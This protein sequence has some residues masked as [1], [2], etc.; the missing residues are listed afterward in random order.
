MRMSHPWNK[1]PNYDAKRAIHFQ[2]YSNGQAAGRRR[3]TYLR[4]VTSSI[5]ACTGK[6]WIGVP[7]DR[8]SHIV[9]LGAG[10][11]SNI[12][13]VPGVCGRESSSSR[14]LWQCG[15][16]APT[17]SFWYQQLIVIRSIGCQPW[18]Y[19]AGIG[20]LSACFACEMSVDSKRAKINLL[21]SMNLTR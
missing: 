12:W 16:C 13:G 6:C 8:F 18:K 2:P 7:N 14:G 5:I 4:F 9:G 20:C 15:V 3:L 19:R 21:V 17:E 11:G 10:N 1:C